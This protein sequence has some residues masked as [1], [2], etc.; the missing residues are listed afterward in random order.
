M[1][2]N[3]LA[4][5]TD[6]DASQLKRLAELGQGTLLTAVSCVA[7]SRYLRIASTTHV[8]SMDRLRL[9]I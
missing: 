6:A 5:G 1:L 2:M 7:H 8:V 4:F 3:T 9:R